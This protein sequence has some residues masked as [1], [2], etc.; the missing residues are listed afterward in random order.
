MYKDSGNTRA[1][2]SRSRFR[3]SRVISH[4]NL[5]FYRSSL[6]LAQ[7]SL[8]LLVFLDATGP[9]MHVWIFATCRAEFRDGDQE[10]GLRECRMTRD[11]GEITAASSS[12]T[13]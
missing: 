6:A 1:G 12:Y 13:A 10:E 5:G 2:R 3:S 8:V 7:V 11:G 9:T 4:R